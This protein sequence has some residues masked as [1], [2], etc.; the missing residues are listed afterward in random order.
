MVRLWGAKPNAPGGRHWVW[1]CEHA[2]V[3]AQ[4]CTCR[5][6]RP[7]RRAMP[8]PRGPRARLCCSHKGETEML[9]G[10]FSTARCRSRGRAGALVPTRRASKVG[11][12]ATR[13]LILG[14][15]DR[16]C[17]RL[18]TLGATLCSRLQ[19]PLSR[20]PSSSATATVLAPR[21]GQCLQPGERRGYSAKQ[22]LPCLLPRCTLAWPPK[23]RIGM[24]RADR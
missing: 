3:E 4:R 10:A 2:F 19:R 24:S 12:R 18:S 7:L 14:C 23:F 1:P 20:L 17:R 15:S 21:L 11:Q 22:A 9:F 13:H 16:Q 5:E 8:P 6:G